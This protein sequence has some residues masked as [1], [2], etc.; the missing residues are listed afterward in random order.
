MRRWKTIFYEYRYYVN[1]KVTVGT[2]SSEKTAIKERKRFSSVKGADQGS[3]F[4]I[5]VMDE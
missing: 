2:C 3:I 1:G 5:Q 4:R